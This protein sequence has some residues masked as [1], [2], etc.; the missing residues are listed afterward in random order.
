M[1]N[2]FRSTIHPSL[3]RTL[4]ALTALVLLLILTSWPL[5]LLQP[6]APDTEVVTDQM[7]T[8]AQV[9]PDTCLNFIQDSSLYREGWDT[10]RQPQ[11]W[12]QIMALPPD[13]VLVNIAATREIVDTLS[14][15]NAIFLSGRL[16]KAYE[17]ST[18][19]ALGMPRREELYFTHGR[20]H[21]YQ[22][23]AVMPD[24]DRAIG[25]FEEEGVDPWYAQAILLIES[26][27]HL[28]V[29]VDGA[30]GAFQLMKGVA[31]EVGLVVNDT[32]DEREDFEKSAMG[33]ARLI[34]NTC[35]PHTRE[36]CQAYELDYEETDLW[37][38]LLVMHVYHAGIR[39]VRRA[40]RKASPETGG[41][42]VILDL[43]Q[44]KSRRFGNA[45]QNYSQIALASLLTLDALARDQDLRCPPP[46]AP[47]TADTL[48][49]SL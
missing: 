32:L 38:R 14:R 6:V 42:Q 7:R 2:L 43:W 24:I 12:R 36:L 10:L 19:D 9:P 37:F 23:Q 28:Q 41:Q 39:N 18:K 1:P 33:A 27:G 35:L 16:K 17:D 30:Y 20:N 22:F 25:V 26:P 47:D 8:A 4:I 5:K 45:S 49:V 15:F 31:R 34:Q 40:I 3:L 46:T 13:I 11:F 44:T 21:F 48:D 29:S